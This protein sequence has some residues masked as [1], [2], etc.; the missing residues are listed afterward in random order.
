MISSSKE[1]KKIKIIRQLLE[2]IA[3]YKWCIFV[4]CYFGS[5]TYSYLSQIT[6]LSRLEIFVHTFHFLQ[7]DIFHIT[8][9]YILYS[10]FCF[11]YR[12]KRLVISNMKYWKMCFACSVSSCCFG[13]IHTFTSIRKFNNMKTSDK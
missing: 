11:S 8:Y 10:H 5:H 7:N 12:K 4:K 3:N 2:T 9:S 1:L 13:F 6:L